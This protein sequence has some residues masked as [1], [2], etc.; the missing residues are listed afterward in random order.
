MPGIKTSVTIYAN[1][2][3]RLF[4]G[5]PNNLEQLKV[6]AETSLKTMKDWYTVYNN[7]LNINK[8]QCIPFATP[9]FNKRTEMFQLTI[10]SM[11]KRR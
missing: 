3:Q 8:T 1:N 11:V 2:V 6:H 9:K 10:D 7:G 5:T 4:G